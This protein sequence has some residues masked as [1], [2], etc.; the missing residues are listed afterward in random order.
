MLEKDCLY[1][2][3]MLGLGA[4]D[5]LRISKIGKWSRG[6]GFKRAGSS[7]LGELPAKEAIELLF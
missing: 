2:R 3:G 1:D 7:P 5:V 6:N 4:R